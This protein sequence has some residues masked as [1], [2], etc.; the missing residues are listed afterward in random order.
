MYSPNSTPAR[1]GQ[2]AR[3][4]FYRTVWLSDTHLCSK[5]SQA[6]VLLSFL[7]SIKCDYL[8]LVGDIID[9]WALQR[10]WHWPALYNEVIHKL[11]KRSRKGAKITFIP[12]NHDD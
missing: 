5:D 11:L 4:R 1:S 3:G 7:S 2:K 8:F 9:M 10:R 6:D 12:G